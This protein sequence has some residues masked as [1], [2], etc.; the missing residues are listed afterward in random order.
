M[1]SVADGG[2]IDDLRVIDIDAHVIEPYDLW[3]SRV[4]VK[5]WGDLVPHVRWNEQ[6]QE[7]TWYTGDHALLGAAAL[8][9]ADS[10]LR[11][12]DHAARLSDV[13]P[14]NWDANERLKVMDDYGIYAQVLYPNVAGNGNGRF[15]HASEPELMLACVQAYNDFL[16]DW[17]APAKER[18][19]PMMAL[20]FWD[21]DLSIAEM[22]R[23]AAQ[24]HRG[25]V[26]T[27]HPEDFGQPSLVDPHWDRLWAAAQ[28]AE[29]SIN[30]H[31]ASG[32]LVPDL[33]QPSLGRHT[34]FVAYA[35]EMLTNARAITLIILAG[36]CHR[37][38]RLRFVS[39]ESGVG[40]I[41]F[42]LASLD[43]KWVNCGVRLEH[44]EY[45]LLPSE[46]F[47]RQIYASFWFESTEAQAAIDL[48]GPDNVMFETDFPHPVSLTP[49]PATEAPAARDFITQQLQGLLTETVL[50]KVLHDNAAQ[51]YHVE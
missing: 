1:M 13:H 29:L 19:L 41:P 42:L 49:G 6:T 20:P 51:L 34:D 47:R 26:F 46:Y 15:V 36:I 12:P 10:P 39:V 32:D 3:T 33:P 14:M 27:S 22:H 45:D 50:R 2:S 23:C 35:P 40:W 37:F 17:T 30:F 5:R 43:W 28:E 25:I 48:I 18:L 4:P 8:A 44:P 21:L 24:R 31:V 9:A 16:T 11:H 7:D 38:P